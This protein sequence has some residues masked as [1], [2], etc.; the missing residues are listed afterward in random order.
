MAE[1]IL[2][3]GEGTEPKIQ[4]PGASITKPEDDLE[5]PE[6]TLKLEKASEGKA[7]EEDETQEKPPVDTSPNV[8]FIGTRR[9]NGENERLEEA[10]ASLISGPSTFDDLP[11]S[12]TQLDGFYYERAAELCRAFPGLYKR[13]IKKGE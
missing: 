2:V 5:K 4:D 1:D 8:I 12:E 3:D 11:D 6:D 9:R 13:L 7:G 10:P